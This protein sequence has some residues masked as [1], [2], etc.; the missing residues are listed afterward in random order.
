MHFWPKPKTKNNPIF[1]SFKAE[2]MKSTFIQTFE[3]ASLVLNKIF[4]EK[5]T[6]GCVSTRVSDYS[7]VCL[8]SSFSWFCSQT[9][10]CSWRS[11]TALYV[12]SSFSS[13]QRQIFFLGSCYFQLDIYSEILIVYESVN[14]LQPENFGISRKWIYC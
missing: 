6:E 12:R 14:T 10:F 4:I 7:F 1:F 11:F 8:F 13:V 5:K 2:L 9:L 3:I